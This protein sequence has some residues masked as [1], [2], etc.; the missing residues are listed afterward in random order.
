[1]LQISKSKKEDAERIAVAAGEWGRN[2]LALGDTGLRGFGRANLTPYAH[3]VMVHAPY[4]VGKLGGLGR[5]SG[6][7]L[8]KLNDEVKGEK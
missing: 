3:L 6:E 1:M 7:R 2:F 8:E 4:M 5:F